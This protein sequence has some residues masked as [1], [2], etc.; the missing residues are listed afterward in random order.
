MSCQSEYDGG[1]NPV[2]SRSCTRARHTSTTIRASSLTTTFWGFF[3]A[4]P[5]P[6]GV[7]PQ[8][9]G[10]SRPIGSPQWPRSTSKST[11]RGLQMPDLTIMSADGDLPS[12]DHSLYALPPPFTLPLPPGGGNDLARGKSEAGLVRPPSWWYAAQSQGPYPE[13]SLL[14]R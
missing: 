5:S 14:M 2:K 13:V 1:E 3:H 7:V 6:G 9:C 8:H 11:L 4:L 12:L 10:S